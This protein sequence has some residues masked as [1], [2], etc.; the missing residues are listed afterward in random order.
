MSESFLNDSWTLYFHDPDNQ[1]WSIKSYHNITSVSTPQDVINVCAAFSDLWTKGMFFLMREHI[2][3]I[4]E[5]PCNSNGGC[6]SIKVMKNDVPNAWR[7]LMMMA[8]GE[9]MLKHEYRSKQWDSVCGISISPKRNY[10]ILRVWISTTDMNKE[11]SFNFVQP[12]YTSIMFKAHTTQES[13]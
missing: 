8:T 6:F 2:Q 4:W 9:S 11:N 12:G 5:D 1:D 7:L 10:C 3:P 13:C